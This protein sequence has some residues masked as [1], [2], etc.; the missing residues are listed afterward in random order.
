ML[1]SIENEWCSPF[2]TSYLI[3]HFYL[4]HSVFDLIFYLF[5][6]IRTSTE[7]GIINFL[8]D[9]TSVLS[10]VCHAFLSA[11]EAFI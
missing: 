11:S 10:I 4:L 2:M 8:M 3:F 5:K 7:A 6:V 1:F 9:F